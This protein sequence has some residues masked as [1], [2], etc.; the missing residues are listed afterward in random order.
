MPD[1]MDWY[2]LPRQWLVNIIFTNVGSGFKKW[3][4]DLVKARADKVFN[5]ED[6]MVEIDDELYEAYQDAP[7]VSSKFLLAGDSPSACLLIFIFFVEHKGRSSG[8]FKKG[9]KRRRTKAQKAADDER[10]AIEKAEIDE[11][12]RHLSEFK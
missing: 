5:D 11:L 7:I 3:V 8:G 9:G 6:E 1:E 2:R 10:E 12:R 4:D